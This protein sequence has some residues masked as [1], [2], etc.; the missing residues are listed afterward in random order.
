M[1]GRKLLVASNRGP[2]SLSRGEDGSVEVKRGGG[3]L[4]SALRDALG[5]ADGLWVCAALN[6]L[7]REHPDVDA[8]DVAVRMLPIGAETFGPA[9]NDIANSTLWFVNHLLFDM[10]TEPVFDAAWRARWDAYVRYNREFAAALAEEAAEGAR[11]AV[12]DYHL[13]LV[14]RLLR[15]RR[16]DLRITH[17]THTPWA[18]PE[19]FDVLP[20]DIARSILDG[21]LGAD[22]LGFH[23]GRWAQA[24]LECCGRHLD[25]DISDGVVSYRGRTSWVGV[26]PLGTDADAL[27]RRAA[28][29]DVEEHLAR[30]RAGAGGRRII[31][32][33]DRTELSKNI[34]RGFHAVRELVR[35]YPETRDEVTHLAVA[36]PSRQ[37]VPAYVDYTE[38]VG[39]LAEE[40]GAE[41]G[42]EVL[43]MVVRNDYAESLAV[44]RAADVLL[45][46]P[47]RDGMNLVAKEGMLLGDAPALVLSTQ[48]GAAEAM[49]AD[50]LLVNPYDVTQTAEALHA[51][52]TMP[53]AER[54]DRA[55]RLAAVAAANP[56]AE[57]F[58][59]QLAFLDSL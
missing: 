25:A 9:Y 4:V 53:A 58:A 29:P 54:R 19:Y 47:I 8:G 38:R 27:R 52:L 51:A 45:V 44:L 22:H 13:F 16:P 23:T 24:F 55:T 17:F 30:I 34:A 33:V 28:E 35:T 11:V 15:Q 42:P 21:L 37:D 20:T 10:P 32:R 39:R 56:P 59:A 14:P 5:P 2:V 36:Y 6:D 46:N 50:A 3:G 48:A 43:R 41:C 12:Q 57:W 40:I 31:A 49:A 18:P 26:H 7:E 1:A